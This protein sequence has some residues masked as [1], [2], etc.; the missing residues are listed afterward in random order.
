MFF[1]SLA[2]PQC[3]AL[4]LSPLS[5]GCFVGHLGRLVKERPLSHETENSDSKDTSQTFLAWRKVGS[6]SVG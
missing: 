2:R 1:Q 3:L 6:A 4:L 5:Q